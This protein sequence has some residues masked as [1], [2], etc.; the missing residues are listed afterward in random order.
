MPE[1]I[2][3]R[4]EYLL[5]QQNI[6]QQKQQQ[7]QT[8]KNSLTKKKK[9]N[10][11]TTTQ[12]TTTKTTTNDSHV[13]DVLPLPY[14]NNPGHAAGLLLRTAKIAASLIS[15]NGHFECIVSII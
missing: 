7:Q 5:M 14:I 10:N 3:D 4:T 13:S 12:T 6:Q 2:G 9:E 8:T 11:T 15:P 1:L